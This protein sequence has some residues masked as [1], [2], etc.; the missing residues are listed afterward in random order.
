M[1]S[2]I[3]NI[4]E[5]FPLCSTHPYPHHISCFVF[6]SGTALRLVGVN[7]RIGQDPNRNNPSCIYGYDLTSPGA[8]SS[9]VNV[10]CDLEGRYISVHLPANDIALSLCEVEF[11]PGICT[12]RCLLT[13]KNKWGK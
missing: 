2:F 11:I 13:Y 1:K 3:S 5:I 9:V 7:V 4:V 10:D 8:G 6:H 12:G